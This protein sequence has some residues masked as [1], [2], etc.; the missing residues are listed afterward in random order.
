[1]WLKEMFRRK[2]VEAVKKERI[3]Q[4]KTTTLTVV[5][6]D[7]TQLEH[8]VRSEGWA[9]DTF[10]DAHSGKVTNHVGEIGEIGLYIPNKKF[11][12]AHRIRVISIGPTITT[13]V[14]NLSERENDV[15]ERNV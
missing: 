4:N 3:F 7:G 9:K 2:T 12:P 13:D 6:D 1:M 10:F 8:V 5:L 15:A 14:V 11:Y